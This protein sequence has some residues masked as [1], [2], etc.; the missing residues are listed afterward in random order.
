MESKFIFSR[1]F[2]KSISFAIPV[3]PW[4]SLYIF[5]NLI[6]PLKS[7]RSRIKLGWF[8]V[9]NIAKS[10]TLYV[11]TS[12]LCHIKLPSVNDTAELD[13]V[14][15]L[16]S[17]IPRFHIKIR[18]VKVVAVLEYLKLCCEISSKLWT[19]TYCTNSSVAESRD[20]MLNHTAAGT[21][22]SWRF[23]FNK[24]NTNY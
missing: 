5:F 16:T 4:Y 22:M 14:Y 20:Q 18:S 2:V 13:S 15:I 1:Q 10:D 21:K 11:F 24:R 19:Y 3:E 8:C 6:I 7:T 23:I 17:Q 12:V 9:N